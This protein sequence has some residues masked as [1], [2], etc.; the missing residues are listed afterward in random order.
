MISYTEANEII[1]KEF[2]NLQLQT[3]EVD[4]L[5]STNRILAEDIYSDIDLPPFTNS[6]MDGFA[7]KFN[8]DIEKWKIIGEIS[9][10][11]FIEYEVDN[12]L[13]VSIMTGGKMP[14]GADTVIPIEDV[15]IENDALI[16]KDMPSFKK[17]INVRLKGNDLLK[18]KLAITKN[19]I[20]K[21]K[22]ISVAASCGKSK[23]LVYKKL[24][25]GVLATGDELVDITSTP[26]EDKI[27]T[28]NLY[29][30][31][32]AITEINHSGI[33]L[34]I[35]KDNENDITNKIKS[36]LE[37]D[38]DILITIGGVS[39]GKYDY[40]KKIMEELGIKINFWRAN[41][42]PGK[43]V[44]FGTYRNTETIK[45]VFGLPGNPVSCL[46]SFLIFIKNNIQV[47]LGITDD[48]SFTAE[49][50]EGIKKKDGKKHFIR[51]YFTKYPDGSVFVKRVG[52]QSS[53][54]LA[55]MGRAN[56][57]IIIDEN[58]SEI[59]TGEKVFCIPI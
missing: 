48:N 55:E 16:L 35:I 31:L 25:I 13:A 3:E 49:L 51:G 1:E 39:V 26:G 10:G 30:I 57:L 21:P 41:I 46:V 15:I 6:A 5:D 17:G 59:K 7:I 47:L 8:P 14:A 58:D 37:S 12:G 50:I 28:S 32:S 36:F 18:G 20:V 45:F 44:V 24:K 34:G 53:G 11:N 38:N 33:N 56:C 43:P 40:V 9:A 23:L 27:R 19:I 52:L 54:N 42:K 22:H 4:I 2:A 29:S